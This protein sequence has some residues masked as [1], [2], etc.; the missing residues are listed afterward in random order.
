L[1][2]NIGEDLIHTVLVGSSLVLLVIAA[3][4]YLKKRDSRYLFLLLAFVFLGL[5]QIETLLET[6][7]L[8]NPVFLPF[9][10]L[11]ISHVLD[12]L[13]LLSFALALTR[14]VQGAYDRAETVPL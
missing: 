3:H 5:S 10:E 7:F 9:F 6:L 1:T 12:F 2:I 14:N 11:H 4:A 13:M 8:E